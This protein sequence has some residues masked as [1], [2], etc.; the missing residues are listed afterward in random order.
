MSQVESTVSES[1]IIHGYESRTTEEDD[2]LRKEKTNEPTIVTTLPDLPV[3]KH[4]EGMIGGRTVTATA[5]AIGSVEHE[6]DASMEEHPTE[7]EVLV[8]TIP[9]RPK[10]D[11]PDQD[12]SRLPVVPARPKHSEEQV[13]DGPLIPRRPHIQQ[14]QGQEVDDP[15]HDNTPAI[16]SRPG[17]RDVQVSQQ[18]KMI[19]ENYSSLPPID[20]QMQ[21][22]DQLH[23]ASTKQSKVDSLMSTPSIPARPKTKTS[24]EQQEMPKESSPGPVSPTL[25]HEGPMSSTS[26]ASLASPVSAPTLPSRPK[27]RHSSERELEKPIDNNTDLQEN[28]ETP[29]SEIDAEQ[30]P[31][32]MEKVVATKGEEEPFVVARDKSV[33]SSEIEREMSASVPT[34]NS[35]VLPVPVVPARPQQKTDLTVID[36][37][38]EQFV[39]SPETKS[40][41]EREFQHNEDDVAAATDEN[42]TTVMK[43]LPSQDQMVPLLQP[44]TNDSSFESD[45][46]PSASDN[47][48]APDNQDQK[49]E[50]NISPSSSVR[51]T[52]SV[53]STKSPPLVPTRPKSKPAAALPKPAESSKPKPPIPVKPATGTTKFNNLRAMFAADLNAKLAQPPKPLPLKKP[54]LPA[55]HDELQPPSTHP[56]PSLLDDSR[57]GRAKGPQRK[58][59]AAKP[60]APQY[61]PFKISSIWTLVDVTPKI[62][63]DELKFRPPAAVTLDEAVQTGETIITTSTHETKLIVTDGGVTKD[64]NAK[65]IVVDSPDQLT[66]H[67]DKHEELETG[68]SLTPEAVDDNDHSKD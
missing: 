39:D 32:S 57:K 38:E 35:A 21:D 58:S 40:H 65:T 46:T 62:N 33:P 68:Q 5:P 25:L 3:R 26:D 45:I 29:P 67:V 53:T 44:Q 9:Q 22:P 10:K 36:E 49:S 31:Q 66:S 2:E 37:P 55:E 47:G 41:A 4:E 63:D 50:R 23:A 17:H 56:A 11:Q 43:E 48:P 52:A 6:Q 27:T 20:T 16:P 12:P 24:A 54:V 59:A 1:S 28:S 61:L 34:E 7:D 8:P 19:V 60:A 15:N 51:T 30:G 18:Q 64:G 13:V 42:V 14:N